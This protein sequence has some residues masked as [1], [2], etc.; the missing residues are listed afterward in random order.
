MTTREDSWRASLSLTIGHIQKDISTTVTSAQFD[1]SKTKNF[2]DKFSL[3]YL[4]MEISTYFS[5]YGFS[6]TTSPVYKLF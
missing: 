5:F 3:K 2:E 4:I 1:K 6:L